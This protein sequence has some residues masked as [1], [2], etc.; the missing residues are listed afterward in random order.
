MNGLNVDGYEDGEAIILYY[1]PAL[2]AEALKST[3]NAPDE[4]KVDA[5]SSLMR[6]MDRV[7]GGSKPQQ[8]RKGSIVERDVSV[9][10][11]TVKSDAFKADPGVLDNLNI[12]F[13]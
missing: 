1:M 12:P 13:S 11:E 9:A 6:F 4:T 3:K 10:Q 7:Y 5:L 8:G 2:F